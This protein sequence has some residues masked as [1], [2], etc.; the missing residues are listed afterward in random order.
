[1]KDIIYDYIK[2]KLVK[3]YLLKSTYV[4]IKKLIRLC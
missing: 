3:I 2:N 4:D 1:M